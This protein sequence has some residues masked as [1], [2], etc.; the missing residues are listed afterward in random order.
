MGQRWPHL[1]RL[2]TFCLQAFYLSIWSGRKDK[3]LLVMISYKKCLS[4]IISV[5]C[6]NVKLITVHCCSDCF[7]A[8]S[9]L[10]W[11]RNWTDYTLSHLWWRF[12][13]WRAINILHKALI[14]LCHNFIDW[15]FVIVL[16]SAI[17]KV[18]QL[19]N[20]FEFLE[21]WRSSFQNWLK[22]GGI[23]SITTKRSFSLCSLIEEVPKSMICDIINSLWANPIPKWSAHWLLTPMRNSLYDHMWRGFNLAMWNLMSTFVCIWTV[24][25]VCIWLTLKEICGS[26]KHLILSA[27]FVLRL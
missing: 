13:Q 19:I 20:P 15:Q 21:Y 4:V 1:D 8:S 6:S 2:K 25:R 16:H 27:L 14:Y 3:A 24:C 9:E 12:D 17:D 26:W 23:T 7:T 5:K 10:S 11:G 22:G 18:E